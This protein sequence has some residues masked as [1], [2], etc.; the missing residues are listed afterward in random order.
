M[1]GKKILFLGTHGQ[2]NIGDELLLETF[3]SE[4]GDQHQYFINSYDPA[5]TTDQLKDRY[6]VQVFHTTQDRR[7]LVRFIRKCDLLFFGGGSILKELYQSVRRN[8]YAT[9]IMVLGI[10]TFANLVARKTVI[11]SNIGVG[12]IETKFG[13][14]LAKLILRQVKYVS[15]R[16]PKSYRTCVAIGVDKR[17]LTSVSDAVF[18]KDASFFVTSSQEVEREP[19]EKLKIALN[20]NYNIENPEHWDNFIDNLAQGLKSVNE[21][22]PIEIY[23]LPMQSRFNPQNDLV[24]LRAFREKVPESDM[25]LH[26][27][28][29]HHDAAEIIAQSD[30]LVGERLHALI[31]AAIL[32][33]PIVPLV[34][35]VKV[36]EMVKYLGM[37]RFAIE[38]DE[39]FDH[40]ALT[41]RVLAL[42]EQRHDVSSRLRTRTS[43]LREEL[44]GYFQMINGKILEI[45]S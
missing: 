14:F 7:Q 24:M 42:S 36:R 30:M 43:E 44:R 22:H 31:M 34:Y 37:E 4:L 11:M 40:A 10:V 9:L 6:N 17:K 41:S 25:I 19:T 2:Y 3:L 16:D 20:L 21:R 28:L 8:R 32:G 15:V 13:L 33:T 1:S 26:E 27:P 5:F 18:A 39:R 12:P 23:A 38:I 45:G 35:D 29:T